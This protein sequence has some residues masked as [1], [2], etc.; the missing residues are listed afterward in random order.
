MLFSP[1]L[2]MTDQHV[3]VGNVPQFHGVGFVRRAVHG[4]YSALDPS[5]AEDEQ[6]M[7]QVDPTAFS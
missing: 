4:A 5:R 7:L 6:T 3:V 2:V 1:Y